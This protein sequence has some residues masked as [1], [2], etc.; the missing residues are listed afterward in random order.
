MIWLATMVLFLGGAAYLAQ[1]AQDGDKPAKPPKRR[2]FRPVTKVEILMHG[3]EMMF[4]GLRTAVKDEKWEDA[5]VH[6]WLLAELGNVNV[7][8]ARDDGYAKLSERMS[9]TTA[10]LARSLKHK[11]AEAARK[12]VSSIGGACKSCHDQYRKKK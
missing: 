4:N 6:A 7:H 9:R 5:E 10:E 2:P 3:Q 11:N 12:G 8:N 1:A